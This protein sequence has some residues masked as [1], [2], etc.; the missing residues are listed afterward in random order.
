MA[1]RRVSSAFVVDDEELQG[2]VTDRDLRTRFVAQALPFD[3]Q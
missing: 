1:E 2:I 3:T